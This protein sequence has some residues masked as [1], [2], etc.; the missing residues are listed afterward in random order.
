[1]RSEVLSN[2]ALCKAKNGLG[3]RFTKLDGLY[4]NFAISMSQ[5]NTTNK[6]I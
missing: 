2:G 5:Q 3:Y 4:I 6:K 1:M